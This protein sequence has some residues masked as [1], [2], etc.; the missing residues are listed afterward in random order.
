MESLCR[1]WN[2]LIQVDWDG[3]WTSCVS[4][5]LSCCSWRYR[6]SQCFHAEDLNSGLRACLAVPLLTQPSL[7]SPSALFSWLL[8][9][10][11][12]SLGGKTLTLTKYYPQCL[13]M[14]PVVSVWVPLC[15]WLSFCPLEF[16]PGFSSFPFLCLPPSC[17]YFSLPFCLPEILSSFKRCIWR[18]F[19][20]YSSLAFDFL[21]CYSVCFHS[22]QCCLCCSPVGGSSWEVVLSDPSSCLQKSILFSPR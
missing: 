2:S 6:C 5:F 8:D 10:H 1:T 16:L 18:L 19:F 13:Q 3:Q 17:T 7:Q 12:P 22:F 11:V 21:P 9:W 15:V 20:Y 4:W 14:F